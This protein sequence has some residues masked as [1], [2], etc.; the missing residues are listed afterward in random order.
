MKSIYTEVTIFE[1]EDY[2]LRKVSKA[3]AEDLLK[4]YS[5]TK[6]V[7]F[8]NS[9]NCH[10]DIFFYDTLEKMNRALDF[11]EFSYEKK[12]FVRWSIVDK[13][14]DKTIGTIELF[15]R[16]AADYFSNCG[17]LRLDLR[18]D[19]EHEN[20]IISILDLIVPCTFE[21]FDCDKIAIKA[22]ESALERRRALSKMGFFASDEVVRGNDGVT[23]YNSYFVKLK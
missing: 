18:S 20:Y 21:L 16:D 1:N 17:L 11:W 10:G 8:F 7:P 9:D 3:D 13:K 6:S 15:H 2:M 4:V 12:Y 14:S 5:D 19:F 23:E 22:I